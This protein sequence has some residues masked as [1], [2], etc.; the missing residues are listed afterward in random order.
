MKVGD[1][2]E[3]I[4]ASETIL[5]KNGRTY[6]IE[7]VDTN[8]GV[9]LV[10]LN[11]ELE[12]VYDYANGIVNVYKAYDPAR[13]RKKQTFRNKLTQTLA[14]EVLT[15]QDKPEIERIEIKELQD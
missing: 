9:L 15:G 5:L 7:H 13:F 14:V 2:V 6:E 8:G 1:K 10:G 3:C 11:M 4:N 12:N